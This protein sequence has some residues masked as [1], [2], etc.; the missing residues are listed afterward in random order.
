LVRRSTFGYPV[1]AKIDLFLELFD[2][3]FARTA[4][5]FSLL[6]KFINRTQQLGHFRVAISGELG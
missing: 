3:G 2:A 5:W 6:Q 4:A 1:S